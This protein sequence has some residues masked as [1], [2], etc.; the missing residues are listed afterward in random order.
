MHGKFLHLVRHGEVEEA[1]QG[2]F[3]GRIDVDLSSEGKKQMKKLSGFCKKLENPK[4]ILSPLKRAQDS[5]NFAV[6]SK[7]TIPIIDTNFKEIHFGNWEGLTFM[8]IRKR[9]PDLY[10]EWKTWSLN[11]RY[12]QGESH[13]EFLKRI[14]KCA[15]LI[16]SIPNDNIVI[17]SHGG[18]IRFLICYF[19][20]LDPSF[21]N[22]FKV[23]RGSKTSLD[24]SRK[25]NVLLDLN[26]TF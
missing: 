2:K 15:R 21:N 6:D 19:L 26:Q 8:Q 4:Y 13:Q 1:Y 10:R 22:S 18:V 11:F 17:F 24:I 16:R 20:G 9:Y 3:V 23:N 14:K 7:N 12:P 5:F 25:V